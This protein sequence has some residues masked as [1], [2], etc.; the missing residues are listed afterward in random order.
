MKGGREGGKGERGWVKEKKARKRW[1]D[2]KGQ[3]EGEEART[4]ARVPLSLSPTRKH[5]P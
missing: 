3:L 4:H 2:P 1:T 5:T